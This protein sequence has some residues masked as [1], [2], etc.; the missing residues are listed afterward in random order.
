MKLKLLFGTLVLSVMAFATPPTYRPLAPRPQS[1]RPSISRPTPAPRNVRPAPQ[2]R[3]VRPTHS[4]R[5]VRPVRPV[6]H[7]NH[8]VDR[9]R[10]NTERNA[11]RE[12]RNKSRDQ[13]KRDKNAAKD[14]QR[15][16]KRFEKGKRNAARHWNGN[17]FDH[18]FFVRNFGVY[19]PFFF[20]GPGFY[21]YGNPCLLGSTFEFG[22]VY[23]GLEYPCTAMW[24]GYPWQEVY[25]DE[26]ADG[27]VLVNPAYPGVTFGVR[28]IF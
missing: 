12:E 6:E 1:T 5:P 27:Y 28:I 19:H 8:N 15:A 16:D 24:L 11:Q 25:I 4:E 23:F 13:A 20:G 17:R 10:R 21:W 26:G 2:P 14:R 22:D 9:D 7:S 3:P 18:K